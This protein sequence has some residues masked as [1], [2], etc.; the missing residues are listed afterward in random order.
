MKDEDNS[1]NISPSISEDYDSLS[2]AELTELKA[3]EVSKLN[4]I[5][6]QIEL[7][8]NDSDQDWY[9]RATA[10][11]HFSKR[12]I[13]LLNNI[14]R[15]KRSINGIA[16]KKANIKFELEKNWLAMKKKEIK[17][18]NHIANVLMEDTH[19]KSIAK[20]MLDKDMFSKIL[21]EHIRVRELSGVNL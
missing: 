15:K 5:N 17:Q 1:G 7:Y 21:N 14:V 11:I 13:Y 9:I 2:I 20:Q 4:H 16:K 19:F 18:A 6:D 12:N 8:K 10:A 3:V